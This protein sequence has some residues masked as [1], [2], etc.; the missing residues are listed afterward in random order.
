MTAEIAVMNKFGVSIAAD[1]AV[2]VQAYHNR[3][4]RRKVYNTANKIFTL[5][6]HAPIGVMFYNAV[7]L[8][9]I[10]WETIVK[11]YRRELG[12][13]KFDHLIDYC[14]D[15]IRFLNAQND[16]FQDSAIEATLDSIFV[17]YFLRLST[18]SEYEVISKE[19]F[20]RRLG[21]ECERLRKL[22]DIEGFDDAFVGRVYD[23]R[24]NLVLQSARK[25]IPKNLAIGRVRRI[26]EL[27]RL[28]IRKQTPLAEQSGLVFTGFGEREYLPAL[29]HYIV[30]CHLGGRARLW[31]RE[32]HCVSHDEQSYVIPFADA[33][34][35]RTLT[36][37]ISPQFH[38]QMA[39]GA[40][41]LLLQIPAEVLAEITEL[42]DEQ[43][44][45]YL[46]KVREALPSQFEQYMKDISIFRYENYT[47]PMTKS[48]ASLPISDLGGVAE[49]LLNSSQIS[50]RV[51]PDI[52]TVGGPIDVATISKGDGFVW[53]KR[54]HYF[55][56]GIN[57]SFN[58]RYLK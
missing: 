27:V 17:R 20:D 12:E 38:S 57:P 40:L 21:G 8:A 39:R 53:I 7:S 46:Q 48:I 34:A 18:N 23:D 41:D 2:T 32:S 10:P 9:G 29:R 35:I 47:E 44:E 13:K 1:S 5:S 25:I 37:G 30:D 28:L 24:K 16:I 55:E 36:E 51:N 54:K 11:S 3:E 19:E 50:K 42:N 26:A 56:S 22:D 43:R 49:S 6:K 52:E 15:F 45:G 31:L 58:S 33:D 4:I 14:N